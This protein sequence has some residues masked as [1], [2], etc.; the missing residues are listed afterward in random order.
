MKINQARLGDGVQG[1]FKV[2]VGEIPIPPRIS[3]L[4]ILDESQAAVLDKLHDF[5][6]VDGFVPLNVFPQISIVVPAELPELNEFA[7][8]ADILVE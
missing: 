2:G 4:R 8:K 3:I 7:R 5:G 6:F 1:S